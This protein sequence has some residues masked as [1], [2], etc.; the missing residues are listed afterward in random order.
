MGGWSETGTDLLHC[1][2]NTGSTVSVPAFIG[3]DYFCESGNPLNAFSI[4]F[5]SDDPLWDGEGCGGIEGHCCN[6]PGIPWLN[7]A[8]NSPTTD[9]IELRV[10]GNE[11]ISNEDT[12]ISQY[13][14]YIK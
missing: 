13:E 8:L 9:D 2:C 3:D 14:I 4:T 11:P 6:V 1:P 12:P 10:C 5:Y 7:K